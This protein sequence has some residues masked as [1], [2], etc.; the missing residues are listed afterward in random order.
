MRTTNRAKTMVLVLTLLP[1]VFNGCKTDEKTGNETDPIAKLYTTTLDKTSLLDET[2]LA[3]N[4]TTG[5]ANVSITV[6]TSK[7]FQ[8]ID[9]FGFTL[10][11]GSAMHLHKMSTLKKANLLQELFGTKKNDIGISYLRI[12]VGASDLDERP[13]SYN[14]LSEETTDPELTKFSLAYDT[15]YLIPIIKE[16]QKIAPDIK[17]MGS[18]WSPPKWMKDNKDTRGGSLKEEYYGSYANYLI[19]YIQA[20]DQKGI[21]IDA[22]TVQNEPLHPGNNPSLYMPAEQQALFIKN[23]LGPAFH[24]A[25]ITT[26]II[27]YDHNADRTDY[28]IHILNDPEAAKFIDGSAFHLYAGTIN[29]LSK[30]HKAH[31]DKNLYFTEQWIGAP[32]NFPGD[33]TWHTENLIVGATRNW[34]KTVLEWNLASDKTLQPHTDRGGCDQCLGALTITGD[35]VIRNPAYYIIAHASK[36]VRPGAVR[37]ESD[38]TGNILNVAFKNPKGHIVLILQNKNGVGKKIQI[39]IGATLLH[40]PLKA[41]AVATLVY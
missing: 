40:V 27:I 18:P 14:D 34:S 30:V 6:D 19:K 31:P 12:S 21:H 5:M 25:K 10:T 7:T 8:E 15:L 2:V 32:G 28:P 26:K 23:H 24:R 11:G 3:A 20:M 36:F 38:I 13:W 16:I 39:K 35:E 29:A 4:Q 37:V 22:L 9:G 41:G 1:P 17:I 33:M